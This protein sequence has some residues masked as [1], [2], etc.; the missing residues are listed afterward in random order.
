[1]QR[2]VKRLLVL[3]IGI[4]ALGNTAV[5]V[6]Q[7]SPPLQVLSKLAL[8]GDGGWDYLSFDAQH[9][10]LFVSRGTRVL[11]V[12]TRSNTQ[13]GT[14][15]DTAGVHG[16]AIAEELGRGYTSNG[17]SDSVTV[18]DLGSLKTL[19][20]ITGTG[21]KPDAIVYD[22][23]SQHVFTLNGKGH[24]ASVIDPRSNR[25]I[26]T[27]ALP[28]K[29]EF[30]VADG[31][32][33]LYANIEDTAQLVQIDT[34]TNQVTQAWSLAPGESPSGLAI[35][36]AH[37]RLFSVC[38]H[39]QMIVLDSTTGRRVATVP[40]GK[41]PDAVVFDPA[42]A[43]IYSANGESGTI[44]AVHEQDADHFTVTATV[45]TQ[46]TA[47]TLALDPARHRLYL[48]AATPSAQKAAN[49]RPMLVPG[50]FVV[51]TVGTH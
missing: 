12:D 6:A 10:H 42:Q 4:V 40:I 34:H 48:S 26:A 28:G 13:T 38:D 35:D 7:S 1:M 17:Q 25:V 33:H 39:E 15:E 27:I 30:A 24:S 22:S 21:A 18:F 36:R 31:A 47:R 5:L 50:S 2:F 20:T 44:T 49:G 45:P 29:P 41:G 9:Q 32:G 23:T 14:I 43:M 19:A 51:L 3:S 11:V 16:I 46:L 37:H 8:G